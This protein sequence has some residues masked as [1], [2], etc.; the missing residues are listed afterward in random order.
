MI[1]NS[2]L[3][4]I[5][6]YVRPYDIIKEI[7]PNLNISFE[8]TKIYNL[9]LFQYH[10]NQADR[11]R[12]TFFEIPYINLKSEFKKTIESKDGSLLF[13]INMDIIPPIIAGKLTR[14]KKHKKML[15]RRK[16]HKKMLTR[17][18]KHKKMLT[19]CRKHKK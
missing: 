10:D 5:F 4:R 17:C 19:R 8:N 6:F 1:S 11:F 2:A 14:R 18:R 9:V 3:D 15:T 7:T 13:T 12:S 16:K